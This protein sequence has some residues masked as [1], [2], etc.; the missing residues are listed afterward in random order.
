M[1]Y[2]IKI[3][4]GLF[5]YMVAIA[6]CKDDDDSGIAGFAIDKEDITIGADGGTDVVTVSSGGEWTASSSEPWVSISPASGSGVTE[7]AIAID[8]TLIKGMRTAEIRFT[9]RGQAPGV[10][11][12]HQTGYGKMIHIEKKDIEI[13]SS[14]KYEE[15][16]FDV[17]VTTN[18]AFQMSVEYVNPDNTGWIILPTKTTVDLDRGSRPRTT[19]IRVDWMMNPDFDTRVAKINFLPQKTEDELEQP[20]S[21]TVTQKAAPKIEDNRTGDSLT[22]LTIRER[23]GAGNNWDPSENMRNW[24][25]VVLWEEGDK[26]LPDDKAVGRIR[27]VNFTLFDTKESIPQEVHYLTYVESLY[28]FSNTNTATKSIKLENDVCGLKYLKKLTVSAYGLTE[29][30]DDLAEKLGNQLELLDISSNNFD[31]IPDILTKENFPVL[32]ILDLRTNRRMV[33]TDLREKDNATKYPDGI[34]MFFNTEKDPSL[35]RLLLWD[36]LEELRLSYNYME[37]TIPDFKVGEDGV[38]GYTDED[39]E[40]FGDTIQYL[41]DHPEIP[42]ILPKAR[43]LSLNLNFF[44]GKLPDWLLY[45]PHLIE[46]NPEVLIFNQETGIDTEGKKARFDNEPATLDYY[47]DAFPKFRKKYQ[48]KK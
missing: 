28:F 9:P 46:W 16:H 36:T 18:V 29:I 39:I 30:T 34:G 14:A 24:E 12:V 19:K 43:V 4:L 26:G 48:T 32:K 20:V 15:R 27:S 41:Y 47:Y 35:R 8:S 31:L 11:T 13:E 38:T 33:L 44:T 37:G 22:L 21:M 40:V 6:A 45:H 10:M 3:A 5:V 2:L 17:T 7:C 25:D 23:M 1:K 42:K